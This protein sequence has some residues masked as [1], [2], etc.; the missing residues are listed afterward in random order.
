M[1]TV[2]ESLDATTMTRHSVCPTCG[3]LVLVEDFICHVIECREAM[4]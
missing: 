1:D 4:R 2:N 3:G